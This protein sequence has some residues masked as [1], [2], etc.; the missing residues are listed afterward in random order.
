MDFVLEARELEFRRCA[1]FATLVAQSMRNE[2]CL[3]VCKQN[4]LHP[5]TQHQLSSGQ[6]CIKS[7]GICHANQST[8]EDLLI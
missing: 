1:A 5:A 2:D 6:K 7:L 3:V 4:T 8:D